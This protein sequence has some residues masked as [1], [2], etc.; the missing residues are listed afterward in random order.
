MYVMKISIKAALAAAPFAIIGCLYMPTM[1][2]APDVP[3]A[4]AVP[5]G[6]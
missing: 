3:A 6:S 5:A 1:S 2:S 4:I